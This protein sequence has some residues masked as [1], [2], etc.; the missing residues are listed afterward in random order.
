MKSYDIVNIKVSSDDIFEYVVRNSN[1]CPIE[2]LIDNQRYAAYDPFIYDSVA[3]EM[4]DQDDIYEDFC[5]QVSHLRSQAS[6]MSGEEI[7]RICVELE[8]I[9]PKTI[10][11]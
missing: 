5:K 10:K 2:V 6:E 8:E 9:A 7:H 1:F 11:L 4:I 3:K